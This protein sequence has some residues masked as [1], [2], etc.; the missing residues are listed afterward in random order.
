MLLNTVV[1]VPFFAGRLNPCRG[2]EA[3]SHG[4]S[5]HGDSPSFSLGPCCAG[6]ASSSCAVVEVT[7]VLGVS[8]ASCGM[9]L[10]QGA[11]GALC[12]GTGP[13]PPPSGRKGWRGRRESDSQV[14]CHPDSLH[15]RDALS[16]EIRH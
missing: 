5:D 1:N 7:A 2:A 6:R 14:T 16:T 10:A 13:R 9:K 15:A 3:S 12:T 8:T 4:L 11:C